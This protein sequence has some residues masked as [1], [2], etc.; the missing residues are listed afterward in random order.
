MA[1]HTRGHSPA[2]RGRGPWKLVHQEFFQQLPDA[3]RRELQIKN[4][5]SARM[6]SELIQRLVG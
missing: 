4:W 2:T 5:K 3:R 6:I 1:E